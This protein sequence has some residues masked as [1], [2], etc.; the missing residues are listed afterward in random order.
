M[1]KQEFIDKALSI[2]CRHCRRR[3]RIRVRLETEIGEDE[4]D[5]LRHEKVDKIITEEI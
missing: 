3:E 1:P 5:Y 4:P 2:M